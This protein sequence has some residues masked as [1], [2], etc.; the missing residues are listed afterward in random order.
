MWYYITQYQSQAYIACLHQVY[1]FE[2]TKW[3]TVG[4]KKVKQ[5]W[6]FDFV[7]KSIEM[8]TFKKINTEQTGLLINLKIMNG[9]KF[10]GVI[11]FSQFS[12]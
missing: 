4:G 3:N 9:T 5:C 6:I 8:S 12:R 11:L 7:K 1:I 2:S 10:Y